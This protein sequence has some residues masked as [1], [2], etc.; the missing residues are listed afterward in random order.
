LDNIR[1][2]LLI[3]IRGEAGGGMMMMVIIII[4]IIRRRRRRQVIWFM[5]M[6]HITYNGGQTQGRSR[7]K[8]VVRYL[9][10]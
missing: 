1:L 7:A 2:G 10:Y 8:G 9:A 5:M 6:S 3:T 4:I